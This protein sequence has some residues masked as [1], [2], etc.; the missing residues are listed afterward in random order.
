MQDKLKRLQEE[1]RYLEGKL[2]R[3]EKRHD[4]YLKVREMTG[5]GYG[6]Y[7]ELPE[8]YRDTVYA[9]KRYL[10]EQN[11]EGNLSKAFLFEMQ[12]FGARYRKNVFK[13]K[14]FLVCHG[15]MPYEDGI[16]FVFGDPYNRIVTE[17]IP[18]TRE[19]KRRMESMIGK[20]AAVIMSV[21]IKEN[22]YK[23]LKIMITNYPLREE[24]KKET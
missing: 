24:E 23:P 6:W 15:I 4:H 10:V 2:K 21:N 16:S 12:Y 5:A 1:N 11:A 17:K 13:I 7:E 20:M 14:F 8:A 3:V 18:Y 22:T 9:K 19:I